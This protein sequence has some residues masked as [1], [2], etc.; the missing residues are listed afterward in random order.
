MKAFLSRIQ[1]LKINHLLFLVVGI[2]FFQQ[3]IQAQI[4]A[5]N[6]PSL[7][8][9]TTG[10][11]PVD[12]KETWVP[13]NITVVS[14]NTSENLNMPMSIRGR[15]NSTWNLQKKPY[16]I[17]LDSKYNFLNLPAFEDD[18]VLLANHA[19]KTLIR[20]AVAFEISRLL[21]FE[22][23]PSARFVDVYLNNV[24]MGNYMVS[25]QVE[26]GNNR[27]V[28]DKLDTL[29][30]T[31]PTIT[32]GYL[33]E[34]DGFADREPV[35]FTTGQS[36]KV[37]VK[38]P[39]DDDIN[40]TQLSYIRNFTNSFENTLFSAN[41][42]DPDIGYRNFVD[43]TSLINWYIACELTGNPDAFWST[44]IYKRRGLNKFFFGPLWD[45]DIAFN[46][47][48]RIGDASN[49]MMRDRAF[50]PKAWIK[51]MWEDEWFRRAVNRR[52]TELLNDNIQ[53]KLLAYINST[54]ALIDASQQKNFA[55]WP[56]LSTRVYHEQF[57]FPTY[58]QGVNFLKNYIQ[59]RIALLTTDFAKSKPED[60]T[61]P[62][63]PENFYYT[64]QNKGSGNRI[65]VSGNSSG[66]GSSLIMWAPVEGDL[67]QHWVIKKL[68]NGYF[69][70][71]NRNSGLAM[72]G[73]GRAVNLIQT[74][75]D[76]QN[77]AQLWKITPVFTGGIYGIE[78]IKS[79]YSVNNSGGSTANG[80]A[81]IEYDNNIFSQ[82]KVNQHW[83]LEKVEIITST[84][85][86]QSQDS[87]SKILVYPNPAKDFLRIDLPQA[88][89]LPV[90]LLHPD[91]RI[92]YSSKTQDQNSITIN[93]SDYGIQKG[94]YIVKIGNSGSIFFVE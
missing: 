5:T 54:T 46:N 16:R 93:L 68:E 82:A 19:D 4:Q 43:T 36:M 28:I 73:N 35:W 86:I 67:S 88:S 51:R 47:D 77:P 24:F 11:L 76:A 45:F 40:P 90:Q 33:L 32:G 22:F 61:P 41:F 38:Y 34:I 9:T 89:D 31:H 63:V 27:V 50:E 58:G 83:Y 57:L 53:E 79:G 91:G 60:P 13:G 48:Y 85:P 72:T 84:N 30:T 75:P 49:A 18:W 2:W 78:N 66:T 94:I 39:K 1:S 62:F 8:L 23:S 92:I 64:I 87:N 37:T 69:Q 3:N 59:N 10:N 26:R 81:V 65:D 20:N 6:L 80:T 74:Q 29:D 42:K 14:S 25:D 12:N 15:G 70:I 7:H 44:Y 52:W 71:I 55:R 21:G 17:K 56:V